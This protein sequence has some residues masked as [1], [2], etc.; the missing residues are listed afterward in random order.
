[1]NQY[2]LID[3]MEHFI[4]QQHNTHSSQAHMEH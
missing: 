1:M 4:Y 2:D 3:I